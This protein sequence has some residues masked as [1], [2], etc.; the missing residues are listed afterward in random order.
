MRHRA[1][2]F[3]MT[4]SLT[5]NRGEG[6]LNPAF[7]ADDA[8]MLKALVLAAQTFVILHRAEQFCTEQSVALGLEC[9]VVDGLR[10]LDLTE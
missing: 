7:F 10:F 1:C 6:N 9:A 3:D 2:Q 8:S 4:H 5:P